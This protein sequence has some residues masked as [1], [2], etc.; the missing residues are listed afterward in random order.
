[1]YPLTDSLL[2][3][4]YIESSVFVNMHDDI[5]AVVLPA[6]IDIFIILNKLFRMFLIDADSHCLRSPSVLASR[7]VFRMQQG[8]VGVR[9]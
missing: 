5:C 7:A 3:R 2:T 1:M 6:D 8:S 4:N 9:L